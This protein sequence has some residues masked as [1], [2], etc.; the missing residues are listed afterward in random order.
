MRDGSGTTQEIMVRQEP[1]EKGFFKCRDI[2]EQ[3]GEQGICFYG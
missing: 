1:V 3:T 2:K